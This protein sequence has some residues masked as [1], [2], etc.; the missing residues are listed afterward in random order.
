MAIVLL[1]TIGG[2]IAYL[3]LSVRSAP[4]CVSQACQNP[5]YAHYPGY[6]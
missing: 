1:L 4:S 6:P 2:G 5:D 3:E